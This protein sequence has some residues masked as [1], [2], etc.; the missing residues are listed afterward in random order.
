[1]KEFKLKLYDTI[2]ELECQHWG[3]DLTPED[4]GGEFETIDTNGN[5]S[6]MTWEEMKESYDR[7]GYWGFIDEDNL[8]HIWI[9]DDYPMTISEILFFLGHEMGHKMKGGIAPNDE[10]Y[11]EDSELHFKEEERA[12][13]YGFVAQKAFEFV[14]FICKTRKILD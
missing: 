3:N 4:M 7:M 6:T 1:M 8:I 14:L 10:D 11:M 12:D 13:E 5:E 2:E 9:K